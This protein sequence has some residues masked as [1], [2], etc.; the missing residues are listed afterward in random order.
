MFNACGE[1]ADNAN[2][3]KEQ[4]SSDYE[5][6]NITNTDILPTNNETFIE[7]TV[8]DVVFRAY[9]YDNAT[10]QALLEHFP[11]TL[12]MTDLHSN[13]KYCYLP[14]KFST[15]AE[16]VGSIKAGDLMLY[17]SD[18][19][20]LF[21]ESFSTSYSYTSLGYIENIIGLKDALGSGSVQVM[22]EIVE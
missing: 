10:T 12:D 13:E 3:S 2:Q 14:Y 15:E 6:N 20:V 7:I 22:F 8:N 5:E 17:G 11:M 9:L 21:Y 19:L 4:Q 18:C 1:E 16:R